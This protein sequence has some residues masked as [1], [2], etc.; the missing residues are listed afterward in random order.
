MG[1]GPAL[2]VV[3][4]LG[5]HRMR[6]IPVREPVTEADHR[7]VRGI[8]DDLQDVGVVPHENPL[9]LGLQRIPGSLFACG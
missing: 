3:V 6:R 5:E 2:R 1:L 7:G 9:Q 8:S 4:Q